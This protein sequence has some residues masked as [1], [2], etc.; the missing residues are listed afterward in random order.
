MKTKTLIAS[1]VC[2][3]SLTTTAL[4]INNLPAP[5]QGKPKY[6]VNYMVL[7]PQPSA[8]YGY[9]NYYYPAQPTTVTT[10]RRHRDIPFTPAYS[11]DEKRGGTGANVLIFDPK[12]LSWGAYDPDGNLVRTGRASGGR[13]YC[14]DIGKPCRTPV[15]TFSVHSKGGAE[16]VS[17]KFPI[18]EGGA[19]MP[20]CMFFRGGY[21][22]HGSYDVP[23]YNASHGCVRLKPVDAQWLS[24]NFIHIGTTVIVRPY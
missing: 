12:I 16:C 19:P 15:G 13:G 7:P 9:N 8:Q 23:N 4:A 1:T 21:A 6:V 20:Y 14:R 24:A 18:G 11:F 2:L 3:V 22:L 10:H 5:A 17:S